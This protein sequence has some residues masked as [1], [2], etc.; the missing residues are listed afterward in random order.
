MTLYRE[1]EP[2]LI[3]NLRKE[4]ADLEKKIQLLESKFVWH[5]EVTI[6]SGESC[7]A[8]N[9]EMRTKVKIDLING[10]TW[11][12]KRDRVPVGGKLILALVEPK[13]QNYSS[14]KN[15]EL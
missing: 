14:K 7:P 6:V 3:E 2:T 15:K 4:I 13:D 9:Q 12:I 5:Q 8:E 1:H 11:L 10:Y